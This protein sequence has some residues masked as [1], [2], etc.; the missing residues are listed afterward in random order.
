MVVVRVSTLTKLNNNLFTLAKHAVLSSFRLLAGFVSPHVSLYRF[1]ELTNSAKSPSVKSCSIVSLSRF[2]RLTSF[3]HFLSE[4]CC[5]PPAV[6]LVAKQ[7]VNIGDLQC[8]V[9][10][11]FLRF[12]QCKTM[13]V[14]PKFVGR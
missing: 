8:P 7:G 1:Y 5:S 9:L 14:N 6:P 4:V 2:S 10:R 3:E 13:C 12:F 11:A